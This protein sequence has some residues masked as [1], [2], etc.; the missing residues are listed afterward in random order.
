MKLSLDLDSTLC[1]FCEAWNKWLYLNGYTE[2][3]LE[4]SDIVSYSYH[5][6]TF[7]VGCKDFF[8]KDPTE[9][10]TNWISPYEGAKE[11]IQW[12]N[13]NIDDIEILTHADKSE[14]KQAK[15]QFCEEHLNFTK[16]RFIDKLHNKYLLLEDRVLV[17]DYPY[18]VIK[19]V[20]HNNNHS[21]IFNHKGLNGWS[22]I[23]E[24]SELFNNDFDYSK[25]WITKD[26]STTKFILERLIDYGV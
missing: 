15:I 2:T 21:I 16:L 5:N 9:C 3:I 23:E 6:E 7:G 24:Y 25:I 4:L 14:T 20:S 8:I 1:N 10:Y 26:Y 13:N 12:C 17:D 11:F 18:H 22:K 19:N